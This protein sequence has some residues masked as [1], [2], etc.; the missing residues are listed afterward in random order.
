MESS[1][2]S[3]NHHSNILGISFSPMHMVHKPSYK[4]ERLFS[5][6]IS[7]TFQVLSFFCICW[8]EFSTAFAKRISCIDWKIRYV[9]PIKW[10]FLMNFVYM[11]LKG[12]FKSLSILMFGW[13]LF[14]SVV[15]FVMC[16]YYQLSIS[17][18]ILFACIIEEILFVSKLLI[19]WIAI[20]WL[21]KQF[22]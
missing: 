7:Y 18:I 9:L 2:A 20:Y 12:N 17:K 4:N 10:N 13:S 8:I 1:Q 22:I 15:H 21:I 3:G 14:P 11:R 16:L 6:D 5:K 19:N